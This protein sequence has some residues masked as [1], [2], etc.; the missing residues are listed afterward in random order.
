MRVYRALIANSSDYGRYVDRVKWALRLV[1]L[2]PEQGAALAELADAYMEL[3]EF[4]LA[5]LWVDAAEARSP[6][7]T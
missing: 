1:T 2:V 4:Q 6:N 7:G 3:G 5:R